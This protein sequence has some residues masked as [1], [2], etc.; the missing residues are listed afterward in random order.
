MDL[1]LLKA[2]GIGQDSIGF[3]DDFLP[4][5]AETLFA[6]ESQEN[7]IRRERADSKKIP[8]KTSRIYNKITNKLDECIK[9]TA[10]P[11]NSIEDLMTSLNND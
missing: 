9:D 1:E 2:I 4:D 10:G 11:F 7:N 6:V 8:A 5:A 3:D